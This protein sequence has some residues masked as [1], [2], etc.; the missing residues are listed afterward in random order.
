MLIT[1]LNKEVRQLKE[2]HRGLWC[3]R[4]Q[5]ER[6]HVEEL[7]RENIKMEKKREET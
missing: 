5:M 7:V 3:G 6:S 4:G 1:L 2:E